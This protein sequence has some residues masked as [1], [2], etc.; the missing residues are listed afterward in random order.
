MSYQIA[1]DSIGL[2]QRTEEQASSLE[3]T[4]ASMEEMTSTVKHNA[5]S[6]DHAEGMAQENSERAV[7]GGLLAKETVLAMEELS[8]SSRRVVDIISTIDGI[9][10]QTNLLSLNAAVEAAR[11][12]EQGRGV[13]LWS[14]A[15]YGRWPCVRPRR[16]RKSKN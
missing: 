12:G 3:E 15:R 6:A 14:P 8:T 5:E 10:F 16:R 9:A 7:H 4:A 11:A 1:D 2:S 13:L